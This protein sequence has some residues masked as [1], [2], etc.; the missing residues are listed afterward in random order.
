[1]LTYTYYCKDNDQTVE[2][3]HRMTETITTWGDLCEKAG[4]SMGS[5]NAVAHVE[6]VITGGYLAISQRITGAIPDTC[7]HNPESCMPSHSCSGGCCGIG[8][9]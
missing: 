8:S 7:C 6:R 5:T 9:K 3:S 4:I 1:M 2:V